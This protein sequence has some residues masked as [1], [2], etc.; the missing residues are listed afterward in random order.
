MTTI[1][2]AAMLEQFHPSDLLDWC[3]QAEAAGFEAGFMVS[4]HFH[5]W[6]PTQGQSAFAW[7]FMGALGQRTSLRF[8][9]A[10]TCPGF[11][12]HPA[13]IAHAAAT[14]GAMYPGR[15]YLGLGAGEALNEH[16]IGGEWPEI[17]I[18][19]AMM[20]ESIEIINKLF[21][22]K[23]VKHKGEFFTL[24]S[25]KLYTRP[26]TPVPV[27]VA[28]AGPINAKK[29]G[30][31]ADGI[32][33]VGA[34]DEKIRML[35]DKYEEGAR[36]AGKDAVRSPKMLQIHVSWAATD[37]EAVE[38]A[39]VEWPNGG[40]PF[41]KQDIK[42]P[43]DFAAMAALVRPEHFRNRVLM[44]SDLEAHIRHIQHYVDMGF[45]EVHLHNVG[46]N[47]AEFI[48]VFGREVIPNLRLAHV[49]D[50]ELA[51]SA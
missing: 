2:Y 48:E 3:A 14:L 35:W 38:N 32:I 47:Q 50:D 31:F 28:T 36:E 9:T 25:A 4:E 15:F 24:E 23:V 40:M 11:R 34:A 29:T 51:A 43:E 5:P 18:R 46:R 10:V 26:E 30:R 45:D 6:T 44:T 33:T 27:Y 37:E 19:S 22:G 13:V 17:G 8:G 7:S 39:L 41:P 21:S 49:A 1:G 16:V 12:Y 20:F 42:N